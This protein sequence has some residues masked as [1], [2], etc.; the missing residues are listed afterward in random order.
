M[1]SGTTH[2]VDEVLK[3][4]EDGAAGFDEAARIIDDM[5]RPELAAILRGF[6][7][8]RT[9]FHLDL[10]TLLNEI[11]VEVSDHGS[12]SGAI[13]RGWMDLK[14]LVAAGN[15][16][17][18]LRVIEQGEEHAV[19]V[20]Q[21]AFRSRLP[22][23]ILSVLEHQFSEIRIVRARV[24]GFREAACESEAETERG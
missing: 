17:G 21:R 13:H 16:Q 22:A 19:S 20:Y 3:T 5:D 7:T 1:K 11:G 10:R 8:Q 4:L 9:T 6:A 18:V 23:R 24:V 14:G 15:P 12:V 2:A